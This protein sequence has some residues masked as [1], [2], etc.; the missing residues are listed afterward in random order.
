M[1]RTSFDHGY[2][3]EIKGVISIVE[4]GKVWSCG[5]ESERPLSAKLVSTDICL[6]A[7]LY[8]PWTKRICG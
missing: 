6:M 5:T 1:V 3:R 7:R 4:Q 2:R 8:T